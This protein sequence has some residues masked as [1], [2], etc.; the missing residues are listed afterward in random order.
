MLST[1]VDAVRHLN[2]KRVVLES[3]SRLK[4]ANSMKEIAKRAG[5]STTTV[6]HV[7]NSTRYVAPETRDRIL[8]LIRELGYYKDAHA[9]RLARGRSDSFGLIVS[10]IGNPFFAEVI[11]SFEDNVIQGGGDLLLCNTNYDPARSEAAVR[12]MIENKVRGVALMTCEIPHKITATLAAH[13]IATVFLDFGAVAKYTS[14][15]RVDYSSGIHQAFDHLFQLGHRDFA[16][17]AGPQTLRSS[18][19]RREAFVNALHSHDIRNCQ[20]IEGNH[21]VEGGIAAVHNLLSGSKL[22][23]G[24]LCSNDLTAIGALFALQKAGMHVPGDVSVVGFDNIDLAS[25]TYP[26]LTTVNLPRNRLGKFAF[27]A[28]QKIQ[29]SEQHEGS[30]Y[31][32][33]THLM[34]RGST[35]GVCLAREKRNATWDRIPESA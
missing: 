9:R 17:I 32:I 6:S 23:T 30:E 35:S 13:Q 27:E 18:V 2:T 25:L 8:N 4:M 15:I 29:L 14:N 19:V 22:V 26:P 11:K 12:K 33:K 3:E 20:V 28:L 7:I 31:V 10:D 1:G 24:I 5:V 34:I 21:G 16:F